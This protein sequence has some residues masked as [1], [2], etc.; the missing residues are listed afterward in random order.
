MLRDSLVLFIKLVYNSIEQLASLLLKKNI[1]KRTIG[2]DYIVSRVIPERIL[3]ASLYRPSSLPI[4]IL[5]ILDF[6]HQ[7][8][9][10]LSAAGNK[11]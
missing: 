11:I 5:T 2:C 10:I 9:K 8:N 7:L 1:N 6:V 4:L 3:P